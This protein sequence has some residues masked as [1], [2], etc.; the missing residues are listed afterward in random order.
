MHNIPVS[1]SRSS[2]FPGLGSITVLDINIVIIK[3]PVS[4]KPIFVD[5]VFILPPIQTSGLN[6]REYK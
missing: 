6:L 5:R 3:N 2:P 4:D 1:G